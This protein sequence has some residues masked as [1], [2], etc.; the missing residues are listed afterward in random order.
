VITLCDDAAAEP[1]PAFPGP[2][3]R[4]H[5]GLSDPATGA[6][7]FEETRQSIEER[8]DAFLDELRAGQDIR[9]P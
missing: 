9:N 8:I 3:E 1:C 4:R 6:T 2:A 7:S 5:W